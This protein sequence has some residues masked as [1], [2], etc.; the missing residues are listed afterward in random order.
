MNESTAFKF[1]LVLS[2]TMPALKTCIE[3]L[4]RY[5]DEYELNNTAKDALKS[6]GW[7]S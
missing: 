2:R 3:A 5:A 4:E 7:E 6:I 1:S